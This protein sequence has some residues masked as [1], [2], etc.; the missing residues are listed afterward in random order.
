[1]IEVQAIIRNEAGIHCRPSAMIVKDAMAYPGTII[2]TSAAGSC[3]LKSIMGLLALG[4]GPGEEITIV[5]TGPDEADYGHALRKLF[6]T[7]FDFP[8]RSTDQSTESL[9]AGI[10]S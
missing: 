8:P 2:V 6:E 7:Q 3:D 10:D 5:V 9:I 4:L 1:M